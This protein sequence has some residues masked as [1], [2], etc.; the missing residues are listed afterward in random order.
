M[1]SGPSNKGFTLI[2]VMVALVIMLIGM[3]G[4]IGMQY[5][6]VTGNTASREMRVATN[7]TQQII[8]QIRSTPYQSLAAGTDAPAGDPTMTGGVNYTRTWWVVA[9][10]VALTLAGDDNTCNPALA[11]VCASD[12]DGAVVVQSSAIRA[13]TCWSDKNGANHSVTLDTVRW[14]ENATP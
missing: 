1:I 14:N 12:P 2:E 13:R 3:L 10:C 9:D 11:A 7:L 4:V 5:Y 8:E 6:A